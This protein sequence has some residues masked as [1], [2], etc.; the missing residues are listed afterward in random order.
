MIGSPKAKGMCSCDIWVNEESSKDNEEL[1]EM[2]LQ[3]V[4]SEMLRNLDFDLP[5]SE[6]WHEKMFF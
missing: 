6:H 1:W 4:L 2:G 3:W 5:N